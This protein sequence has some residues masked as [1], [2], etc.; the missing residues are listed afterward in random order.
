MINRMQRKQTQQ[1]PP[2][3]V[4]IHIDPIQPDTVNDPT[5]NEPQLPPTDYSLNSPLIRSLVYVSGGVLFV[6]LSQ[7]LF[8][9]LKPYFYSKDDL[10]RSITDLVQLTFP[11]SYIPSSTPSD[12]LRIDFNYLD[13]LIEELRDLEKCKKAVY[14]EMLLNKAHRLL[15][16]K[17]NASNHEIHTCLWLTLHSLLLLPNANHNDH[18]INEWTLRIFNMDDLYAFV[19]L[20]RERNSTIAGMRRKQDVKF[21]YP[22]QI[23]WLAYAIVSHLYTHHILMQDSI[24][25][26]TG[27]KSQ[28]FDQKYLFLLENKRDLFEKVSFS[29]I[30][31]K[32]SEQKIVDEKKQE[33][34]KRNELATKKEVKNSITLLNSQMG[35]E[36]FEKFL[37]YS[38]LVL[39]C[40]HSSLVRVYHLDY[41]RK[42]GQIRI[43][44]LWSAIR[45]V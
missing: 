17:P 12:Q 13:A 44:H 32:K 8:N 5:E 1:R 4:E 35:M 26:R 19:E 9:Y 30:T 43:S 20:E 41:L 39:T 24:K 36:M 14:D 18:D 16:E 29:P 21:K 27:E 22:V 31:K 11:F 34:Y 23:V 6:Y 28:H 37:R 7:H 38:H 2:S 40:D 33:K 3:P 42:T 45:I 10:K 25:L 15:T